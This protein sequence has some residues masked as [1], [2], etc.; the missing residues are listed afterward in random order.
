MTDTELDESGQEHL[1]S[2][3]HQLGDAIEVDTPAA[4]PLGRPDDPPAAR[5]PRRSRWLAVAA[6]VLLIGAAVGAFELTEDGTTRIDTGPADTAPAPVPVVPTVPPSG[7]IW[8]LPSDLETLAGP[9]ATASSAEIGFQIAVD[10]P[11]N[12]SAWIA[13]SVGSYGAT[14]VGG[15]G[16]LNQSSRF[17]GRD[18]A[19]AT[20]YVPRDDSRTGSRWVEV[21]GP[22]DAWSLTMA[23]A[24]LDEQQIADAV[25]ALTEQ[26]GDSTDPAVAAGALGRIELPDG[27]RMAPPVD[28]R[29]DEAE[30]VRAF[31]FGV[32]SDAT[33]DVVD[34]FVTVSNPQPTA[35]LSWLTTVLDLEATGLSAA[36]QDESHL[37]G[38]DDLSPRSFVMNTEGVVVLFAVAEDGTTIRI[39]A[40]DD[41]IGLT[42]AEQV[43]RQSAI[44]RGL[45][46]LDEVT[47]R[48]TL[49]RLGRTITDLDA[50]PVPGSGGGPNGSVDALTT[51]TPGRSP[52]TV[53]AGRTAPTPT[54]GPTPTTVAGN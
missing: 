43:A 23:T 47:V 36:P 9:D 24:G 18:G 44:L 11:V 48:S 45:R 13:V 2:L 53:P 20:L 27:L 52:T 28:M 29:S 19:G 35:A 22:S 1:R 49:D 38:R 40:V 21:Q 25:G 3:F 54:R 46:V 26:I 37:D 34:F 15:M 17:E 41:G 10:D 39:S 4:V 33:S 14:G 12:P 6:A 7:G 30:P 50:A 32:T 42:A 8:R 5:P 51:S 16:Q 31:G